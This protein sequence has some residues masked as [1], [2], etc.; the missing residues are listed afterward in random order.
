MPLIDPVR[1]HTLLGPATGRFDVD[2]TELC[3]STNSELL[4][5]ADQ[6]APSGTVL[7]ADRQSAGRGRR[8]RQWIA[9]PEDALMFSLL[10]RFEGSAT[11]L[12]GLSLAVGVAVAQALETLG[13]KGVALKWPNDVLLGQGKLAGIL[14]ELSSD[15]RG[16]LTVIG[17]GL[18]LAAP[19]T[20]LP[21]AAAG[22][23][24]ATPQIP[25]RHA[26]LAQL[27][28]A[29]AAVF[30]RFAQGGF[31]AL[32]S[33]WQSRHAWQG[34]PVSVLLDGEREACGICLGA[35][36]DGALLVDTGEGPQRFLSGDLSLRP[37]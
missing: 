8:G 3:D 32:Q 25:E 23:S 24:D 28:I 12:A 1:L 33:A 16:T 37:A 7:V 22:L 17:I 35:D 31:A 5:R 19:R 14:V 9:E 13:I 20:P 36:E 6:G 30:D 29:L 4:R 11:R 34:R 15:R 21:Q 2:S 27:L 10:W 18:N 26:L